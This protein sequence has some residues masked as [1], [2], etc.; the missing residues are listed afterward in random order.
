MVSYQ[1]VIERENRDRIIAL[2]SKSPLTFT[3][4]IKLS[5]L[6]RGTVNRHL[7]QMEEKGQ[8]YR[9]YKNKKLLIKLKTSKKEVREAIWK[10]TVHNAIRDILIETLERIRIIIEQETSKKEALKK[11]KP[12]IDDL[13]A[14]VYCEAAQNI[15]RIITNYSPNE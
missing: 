11:I 1:K 12:L 3:E 4:L 6:S 8:I 13:P 7:K 15:S 14:K 2:L 10:A 5:G 9:E